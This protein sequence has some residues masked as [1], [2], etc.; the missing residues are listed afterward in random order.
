MLLRYAMGIACSAALTTCIVAAQYWPVPTGPALLCRMHAGSMA[1]TL[2]AWRRCWLTQRNLCAGRCSRTA[3]QLAVQMWLDMT[4]HT[5]CLY[6]SST[7]LG[8]MTHRH[9]YILSA[10]KSLVTYT[11]ICGSHHSTY[12]LTLHLCGRE[13]AMPEGTSATGGRHYHTW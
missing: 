4:Q 9:M 7:R 5:S 13:G 11:Y 6:L 10:C 8:S 1:S 12:M 2:S 3:L